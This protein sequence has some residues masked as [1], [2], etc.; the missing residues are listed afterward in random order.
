MARLL[1][2]LALVAGLAAGPA[3]AETWNMAT[4]YPDTTFHTQ[5]IAQFAQEV[6]TLTSGQLQIT[7]H[8]NGS[9][10]RMPEIRRALITGQIQMGEILISV[11]ANENPIYGIDSV[12][13]LATSFDDAR[14]LWEASHE[15]TERLLEAD[16][17]MLLYVVPWPP[18]GLYTSQPVTTVADLRG[19]PFRAYNPATSRIAEL[20][21][22]VPTQVEAPEIPQAFATGIVRAMMTSPPTG[23]SSSAWDFVHYYYDV[24]AWIPKNMIV[25]NRAAFEALSPDQQQALRAA[26]ATAETRGWEMARAEAAQKTQ[27]LV[28][29]GM[30]VGP[31]APQLAQELAA[32]GQTMTAEWTAQAGAQGEAIIARFRAH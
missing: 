27:I 3:R 6:G 28:D 18:Q 25:V 4:G 5:N 1:A 9:L 29:H 2:V 15:A 23:V 19:V 32:I 14:R 17:L 26:A 20:I 24:Q 8:S 12:P 16:G 13:F 30:V 31:P 21:G 10:F 22:A 7:V 11:L